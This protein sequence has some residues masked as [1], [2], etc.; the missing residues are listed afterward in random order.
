MSVTLTQPLGAYVWRRRDARSTIYKS[1]TGTPIPVTTRR[2]T[3][4][5]P[6]P[7]H[8]SGQ[9]R[10]QAGDDVASVD[11]EGLI[12]RVLE[13]DDEK[14]LTYSSLSFGFC[15]SVHLVRKP[16]EEPVVVKLYSDLSLLRTEPNQRGVLDKSADDAGMGPSVLSSTEEGIA[17]SFFQGR[18]LEEIDMHTRLDVGAAAAK[19]VAGFHSL[20]VPSA[21]DATTPLIWNWLDRMLD[22]IGAS[23]NVDALPDSVNLQVLRGEVEKMAEAVKGQAQLASEDS[24][25]GLSMVLAHGDLKP[26]NIMLVSED[27]VVEVKLI[28]LELAGP[29][30]RG[31]DLMKLFRT[32]PETYSD[33]HFVAFLREYCRAAHLEQDT[34]VREIEAETK[35][36]EPLTWL[37]AVVFFAV[38]VVKAN[39]T[40]TN[41]EL[42]MNRWERYQAKRWMVEHQIIALSRLKASKFD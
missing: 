30:Y 10:R 5:R 3:S 32:N 36:F 40:E 4:V 22:E 19:L 11:T 15:N 21:F 33:V 31:F 8:G 6:S 2:L 27:P 34:A 17:H 35:L 16:N 29:N 1:A 12:R 28:D 38:M 26:T 18:V 7:H 24:L 39:D 20:P 9:F 37:E 14:E 23:E 41:V 25:T 13:I 42:L